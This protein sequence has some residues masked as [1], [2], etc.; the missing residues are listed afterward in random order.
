MEIRTDIFRI[1]I[2]LF[3]QAAIK[4]YSRFTTQETDE[5]HVRL[6]QVILTHQSTRL[7]YEYETL[8]K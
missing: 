8:C 3:S 4:I 2:A 5:I 7:I 6:R 1:K